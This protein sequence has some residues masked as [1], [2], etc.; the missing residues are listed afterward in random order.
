MFK[1]KTLEKWLV[2]TAIS[3]DMCSCIL[4]GQKCI[5]FLT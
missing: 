4:Q 5:K 1:G 2:R 3:L